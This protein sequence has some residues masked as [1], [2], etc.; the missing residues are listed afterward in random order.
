MKKNPTT[1]ATIL[2]PSLSEPL[3]AISYDR[4]WNNIAIN[5]E[6]Q[7]WR[8]THYFFALL[9]PAW[10]KTVVII[11]SPKEPEEHTVGLVTSNWLKMSSGDR[12]I[13]RLTITI[14]VHSSE[15]HFVLFHSFLEVFICFFHD[16]AL[17]LFRTYLFIIIYI[18]PMDEQQTKFRFGDWRGVRVVY[19]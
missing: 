2:T 1:Y 14:R 6:L 7:R 5:T 8:N 10:I 19:S 11:C 9:P 16:P 17:H 3:V 13:V 12:E 15:V 4:K 18:H